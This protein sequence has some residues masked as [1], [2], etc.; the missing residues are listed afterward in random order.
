M[1]TPLPGI[2]SRPWKGAVMPR[3]ILAIRL[4]A[5]G[6]LVI[7]LPYLQQL[8][9]MLPAGT[10]LDLLTREEVDAIPRNIYLFDRVYS[11]RGGRNVKKQFLYTG[12]LLPKLMLSRYDV[13]IDLQNNIVSEFT[14]RAL[15]PK[16][17]S[18]FDR[19]SPIAAGES[20]RLTIEA[21]DLGNCFADDTGFKFKNGNEVVG[22][23]KNNGWDGKSEL[24]IL[25]P[26]GAFITRNWPT[27]NYAGFAKCWL[28][29]FPNTQF[30]VIGVNTILAKAAV[31]KNILGDKLIDLVNK[32]NPVQAFA[33]IQKVKFVL[34][35]DS[36]LMHMAW[37]SGIPTL[38][39]FGSTRSDRARP[40][41]RHSLLLHSSDLVCGN[42]MQ[43]TCIYGNTH[44]L[45][46]Y[47]PEFVF[48]KA[49]SLVD[50]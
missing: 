24:V 50:G 1:I 33:I 23:L 26:A 28:G 16:A 30:L 35:E 34:S 48:E 18:L 22:L 20:T 5:M 42:C 4:Q 36:G 2:P 14:R 8:K 47:T 15:M 40:L 41:G 3:R 43:E 39:M 6:D 10:R 11:I 17:W 32:T 7:T 38:A 9:K 29:R 27:E 37:V 49:I 13:V 45:T 21:I 19:F 12:L 31:L 46:R 44:C 25:N